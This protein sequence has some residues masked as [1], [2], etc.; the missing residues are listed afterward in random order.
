[1]D[2]SNPWIHVENPFDNRTK[3]SRKVMNALATDHHSRLLARQPQGGFW[4]TLLPAWQTEYN[5]WHTRYEAWVNASAAWNSCTRAL[6]GLLEQLQVAP[7]GEG[8]SLIDSW[9][10]RLEG[11]FGK[12]SSH[13]EFL[14]PQGREPFTR[15]TREG[16][17]GAVHGLAQRLQTRLTPLTAEESALQAQVDALVAAGATVPESIADALQEAKDRTAGVTQLMGKVSAF[18]TKLFDARNAQQ[19]CEGELRVAATAV[20]AQRVR[21]ARQ[22]FKNFGLI[23]AHFCDPASP[24]PDPQFAAAD[25]FDLATLQR[26]KSED[27]PEEP[28]PEPAPVPPPGP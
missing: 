16:I 18:H 5:T 17:I 27:E 24:A 19:G 25:L 26:P 14:L 4:V 8:R 22:M 7:P 23:L 28:E 3:E 1:M 10:G 21:I 11:L 2:T 15:G 9:A 20:E 6:E 12:A 13:Y